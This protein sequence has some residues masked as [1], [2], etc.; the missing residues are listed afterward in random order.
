MINFTP[1][2]CLLLSVFMFYATALCMG[3]SVKTSIY[4]VENNIV[5]VK[6]EFVSKMDYTN[7]SGIKPFTNISS[8]SFQSLDNQNN[9]H[10]TFYRYNGWDGE[11]GDFQSVDIK[12]NGRSIFQLDNQDGWIITNQC[13]EQLDSTTT[14][15]YLVGQVYNNNPGF[16]TLVL[17]KNDVATLIFN[18]EFAISSVERA[19]EIF[20]MYLQD[21]FNEYIESTGTTVN[22]R[23]RYKINWENGLLYFYML[24]KKQE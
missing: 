16:L 21:G 10:A 24:V 5:M 19:N 20:T 8:V 14:L 11:S 23:G 13:Y 2:K 1:M 9:Y 22:N 6:N 4:S 7:Y 3:Q 15:L 17:L 18:K 12:R